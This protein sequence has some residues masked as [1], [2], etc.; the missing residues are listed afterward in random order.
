MEIEDVKK[1]LHKERNI[2]RRNYKGFE[3]WI[4]RPHCQQE[5]TELSH[6]IRSIHLCGYVTIPKD[7]KYFI[8]SNYESYDVECHGGLT[9]GN[10]LDY[11]SVDFCIGFD[12]SHSY[13]I[14]TLDTKLWFQ[15]SRYR[16]VDYVDRECKS[17]IDQLLKVK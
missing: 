15:E 13:D 5:C 12:C 4:I 7:S 16:N 6:K 9:F 2:Y 17:I 3:Y 8:T 10:S 11:L 14:S 1:E